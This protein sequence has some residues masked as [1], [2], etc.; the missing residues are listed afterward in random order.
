[1]NVLIELAALAFAIGGI[2]G[3]IF[4][5]IEAFR[6]AIWKG[7]L[8]IIGCGFYFLYYAIFEFD[9]DKKWEIVILAL[10]GGTIATGLMTLVHH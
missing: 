4:I 6:D 8:C 5:I 10:G 3:T 2:V 9:H 1:V 7:I